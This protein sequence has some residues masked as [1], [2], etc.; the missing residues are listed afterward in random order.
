[1]EAESPQVDATVGQTLAPFVVERHR[2]TGGDLDSLAEVVAGDQVLIVLA[3]VYAELPV[4]AEEA[5]QG[6]DVGVDVA[7]AG[8]MF[9]RRRVHVAAE[10]AAAAT[11]AQIRERIAL[12]V[13]G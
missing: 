5:A 3:L 13:S 2:R 10:H 1:M 11:A 7:Q 4:V 8:G 9:R 12:L 6:I